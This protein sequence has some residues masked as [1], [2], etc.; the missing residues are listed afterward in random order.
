MLFVFNFPK[1]CHHMNIMLTQPETH[2]HTHTHATHL[3]V[4]PLAVTVLAVLMSAVP[5]AFAPLP[6][7]LALIVIFSLLLLVY[8]L[9][10]QAANV[11][12]Y[13]AEPEEGNA[14]HCG[15]LEEQ[16]RHGEQHHPAQG[17]EAAD[18]RGTAKWHTH[19]SQDEKSCVTK[20]T[21]QKNNRIIKFPHGSFHILHNWPKCFPTTP[22]FK[23]MHFACSEKI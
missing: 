16:G 22:S 14:A 4:W 8:D 2:T 12:W 9:H 20:K 6:T 17:E 21:K 11:E 10:L 23:S 19:A 7:V 18:V 13:C 1:V 5:T 15:A 3:L